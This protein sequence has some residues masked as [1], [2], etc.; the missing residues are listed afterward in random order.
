VALMWNLLGLAG[1]VYE[2]IVVRR[3]RTQNLYRPVLEDWLFHAVLPLAGYAVLAVAGYA[4]RT[5]ERDALFGIA[6]ASLLLLFVGIHNAWDAVTY[7]IFVVRG[8]DH[9]SS[10]PPR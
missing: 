4:A 9:H 6:A 10:E 1:I 7:H 2:F 5:H 8:R 3:M